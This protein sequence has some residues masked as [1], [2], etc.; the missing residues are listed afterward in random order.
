MRLLSRAHAALAALVIL[1][2]AGCGGASSAPPPPPSAADPLERA[3][4]LPLSNAMMK[5]PGAFARTGNPNDPSLGVTWP[6]WP[7]TLVFDASTSITV[8]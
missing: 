7:A 6:R 3:A 1:A 4:A 5:S 8:R 2:L